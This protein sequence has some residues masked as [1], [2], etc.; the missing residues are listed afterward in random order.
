MVSSTLSLTTVVDGVIVQVHAP[1]ALTQE[2]PG[3]HFI[4]GWALRS[5][6]TGAENLA[7]IGIRS[8]DRPA[9]SESL[10]RLRYPASKIAHSYPI[11]FYIIIAK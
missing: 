10:Y 11:L 9:R 2:R 1:A 6:W 4:G 7:F 8:L 3:T 5:V